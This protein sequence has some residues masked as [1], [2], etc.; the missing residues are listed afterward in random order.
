MGATL[1]RAVFDA[2]SGV[3]AR[4]DR[5]CLDQVFIGASNF[6]HAS[7]RHARLDGAQLLNT[8]LYGADLRNMSLRDARVV[9]V[10]FEAADVSWVTRGKPSQPATHFAPLLRHYMSFLGLNTV[11]PLRAAE[12]GIEA[13]D[14]VQADLRE[15]IAVGPDWR[16]H[17]VCA[18]VA[19]MAGVD[20]QSRAA[21]W[22]R[23]EEGSWASPQLVA[24]LS[25]SEGFPLR[26][27]GLLQDV[28]LNQKARSSIAAVLCSLPA[29]DARTRMAAEPLAVGEGR[30]AVRWLARLD[31]LTEPIGWS[32]R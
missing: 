8:T 19:G 30:R 29:L 3:D 10:D 13:S 12:A 23:V 7:F 1:Y 20:D 16:V 31:E 32:P 22:A 17:V 27:S 28:R 5:A 9:N 21:L 26:A 2:V 11:D 6:A 24:A 18:C 15:L 4:F 14:D 25:L